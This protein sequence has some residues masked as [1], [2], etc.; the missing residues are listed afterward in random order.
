MA[1][2]NIYLDN[3]ATTR[4]LPSVVAAME[5]TMT[6][7]FGNASSAHTR[8]EAARQ[9]IERGRS[10]VA[11]LTGVRGEDIFFTSGATE[12]NNVALMSCV[13]VA[14]RRARIV[15]SSVEHS[16]VLKLCDWLELRGVEVVRLHVD[17]NGIVSI[18]EL[19]RALQ[20]P[21]DLVSVQWVNS[22]TGV[23]QPIDEI[24]HLVRSVGS[25]LHVDAAQA[26]GKLHMNAA[27]LPIDYISLTAHKIH[28]PQG[29]GAL[30][31][32]PGRA[33]HRLLHGGPQEGGKR[34]G[35]EN[36]P[37]IAGFGRAAEARRQSFMK[38]TSHM[39]ELRDWFEE[40]LRISL[41]GVSVN[42]AGAARIPGSTNLRFAGVDGQALVARLDQE[43]I[44]C[45]QSS[46]CTNRRPEPSYVLRA[47]GLSETEAYSSVRF[48]FSE[49]NSLEETREA[50]DAIVETVRM[51]RRLSVRRGLC[52]VGQYAQS[53]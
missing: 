51:L 12:A 11:E 41:P 44:Y 27:D 29:I 45:S 48:T 53:P 3:G 33:V 43:G 31:V 50:A 52:A 9:V 35:T 39:A 32:R 13:S 2:R 28:G 1:Q 25:A 47:M 15:T 6:T 20:L 24:G 23:I 8:G 4:P 40:C 49:L 22:E 26:I 42:G 30:Y 34:A 10:A 7:S 16:S 18:R 38:A 14:A 5:S 37:G 17:S 21:T 46:A 19:I 36:T